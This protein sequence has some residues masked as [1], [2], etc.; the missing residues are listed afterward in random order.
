MQEEHCWVAWKW[1]T[2]TCSKTETFVA[3]EDIVDG[4]GGVVVSADELQPAAHPQR[5]IRRKITTRRNYLD[6]DIVSPPE[7]YR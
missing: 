6:S 7:E 1:N 3:S 4:G 5:I 2:S